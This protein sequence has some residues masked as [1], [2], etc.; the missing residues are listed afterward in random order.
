MPSREKPPGHRVDLLVIGNFHHRK[1]LVCV[2]LGTKKSSKFSLLTFR[3]GLHNWKERRERRTIRNNDTPSKFVYIP[4]TS[5]LILA[6][7]K[8]GATFEWNIFSAS[9][10]PPTG[11]INTKSFSGLENSKHEEIYHHAGVWH[12]HHLCFLWKLTKTWSAQVSL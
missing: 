3:S 12:K 11:L 5:Y 2:E 4:M 1:P 10:F 9:F 8:N 6:I 7:L